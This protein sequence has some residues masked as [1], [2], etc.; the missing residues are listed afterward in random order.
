MWTETTRKHHDRRSAPYASDLTGA[1][2][3]LTAPH[4]PAP[5]RLGRPRTTEL[6]EVVNVLFYL[7]STGC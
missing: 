3:A 6:R 2:W 1:E 7:L 5:R 4:L